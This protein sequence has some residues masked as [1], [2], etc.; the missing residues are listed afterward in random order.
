MDGITASY[1][2]LRRVLEIGELKGP[3]R[4]L[5]PYIAAY[6]PIYAWLVLLLFAGIG[7]TLF[8]AWFL[9][10]MADAA[11]SGNT[12]RLQS[13]TLLGLAALAV[14]GGAAYLGQ[15]LE[16]S[17]VNFVKR[18]LQHD[19]FH[20]ML[21]LSA[22]YTDSRHSG[23]LVSHLTNDAAS[24]DGAVGGNL[25]AM[26]R[27]PLMA[28]AAFAYLAY[29]NLQ[30][31]LVC[32]LLGP[33]AA[34]SGAVFGKLMR[35]RSR[36]AQAARADMLAFLHDVLSGLPIVRSFIQERNV[37]AD[38]RTRNSGIVTMELGL[39]RLRGLFQAGAGMAGTLSFLAS[40]SL[41]SWYVANGTMT[42]GSLL[43]FVSLMQYLISPLAGM[44]S[45][46]GGFQ[47]SVAAIERIQAVLKERPVSRE[48][49]EPSFAPRLSAGIELYDVHFR[50][51]AGETYALEQLTLQVKAGSTVAL[52]GPSGA[53]KSTLLQLLLGFYSA[54]A[55]RIIID[56][57]DIRGM[58]LDRLRSYMAYVPQ[59]AYLFAGTIRD[60]IA[61]GKTDAAPEELQRAAIHANAHEFIAALPD[62]YDTE[63]GERGVRLSGGQRQRIAIARALL[64]DAP[65]LLLDE[66]TSALDSEAETLVQEALERLMKGRTTIVIAHRLSTVL[67]ADH[68][69][70]LD[71][72]RLVEQGTHDSLLAQGGAYSKLYRLQFNSR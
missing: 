48:L 58:R 51:P 67:R 22:S 52:V 17:A 31:S 64:K 18:D 13:L 25:L 5:A 36:T 39:A 60:N 47:R 26:L 19:L 43:A 61:F 54:E 3:I 15:Y 16:A 30:L 6:W 71:R 2:R 34:V 50:Y 45:L 11:T 28:A 49:P 35:N 72:G 27:L 53:G 1:A 66:A 10:G 63:V 68:I 70:V 56:G 29:L 7:L 24:I 69:A 59:D 8:F 42:I 20:H 38:Y 4:L 65:V 62:G 23:E 46:W 21:R 55:G 14:G 44:A 37:Y 40:L 12:E 57:E 33:V 41:G 32:L 9:Q